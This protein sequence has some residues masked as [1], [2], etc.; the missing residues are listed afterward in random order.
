MSN[1]EEKNSMY[2]VYFLIILLLISSTNTYVYADDKYKALSYPI[3]IG[4]MGNN[5]FILYSN[6]TIYKIL[7]DGSQEFLISIPASINISSYTIHEF[8]IVNNN[9]CFFLYKNINKTAGY[10]RILVWDTT[11]K[12][13]IFNKT[14]VF[15]LINK[16]AVRGNLA[17][18]AAMT[19]KGLAVIISNTTSTYILVYKRINNTFKLFRTYD[20]TYSYT[21]YIYNNTILGIIPYIGTYYNRTV[22]IPHLVDLFTNTSIFEIPSL[23]PV[24]PFGTP[25]VQIYKNMTSWI[26][27]VTV[28]NKL[29]HRIEYYITKPKS[30]ELKDASKASFSPILDCAVFETQNGAIILLPDGTKYFLNK[31]LPVLPREVFMLIDPPNG[32]IDV[33]QNNHRMLLKY[34]KGNITEIFLLENNKLHKIYELPA[35]YSYKSNGFYGT[36]KGNYAFLIDPEKHKLIKINLEEVLK[37]INKGDDIKVENNFRVYLLI[38]VFIISV[39]IVILLIKYR[40]KLKPK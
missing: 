3:A 6:N 32:I 36:I 29:A 40:Y 30:Y 18:I 31:Y 1:S 24:I 25:I 22:L 12:K 8:T 33:D 5:R 19:N 11:S 28:I 20:K 17:T 23:I 2:I 16:T 34:N 21:L 15:S 10:T 13:I 27:H 37:S 4:Y 7:D 39:L 14:F 9:I 38:A 35:K 26:I